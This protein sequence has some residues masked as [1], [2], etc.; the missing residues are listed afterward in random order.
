MNRLP[1]F[2]YEF[3]YAIL[4]W[5][6]SKWSSHKANYKFI[7]LTSDLRACPLDLRVMPTVFIPPLHQE[8]VTYIN[9]EPRCYVTFE[10]QTLNT[11]NALMTHNALFLNTFKFHT[12]SKK[13]VAQ[14]HTKLQAKLW[15]RTI[16][17]YRQN[18][19]SE[20]Y[21]TTGKIIAYCFVKSIN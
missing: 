7:N 18:C 8:Y 9:Y 14:N 6:F 10:H 20:P 16:Q 3:S 19:G 1:A 17:N 12:K 2:H 5:T 21:K 4:L 15:L 11:H 13:F